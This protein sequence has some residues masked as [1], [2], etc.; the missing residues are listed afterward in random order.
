MPFD[1]IKFAPS[2]KR[3]GTTGLNYT[4]LRVYLLAVSLNSN[5]PT[6]ATI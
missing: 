4:Y 6:V 1:K 2:Q 5:W 3:L